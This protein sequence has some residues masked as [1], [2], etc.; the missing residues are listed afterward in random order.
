MKGEKKMGETAQHISKV[1]K[2]ELLNILNIAYSEEWLAYYQYWI[3]AQVAKGPM[4]KEIAEEFL[5]HANEELKHAQL[6]VNR[7]IQLGGTPVIDPN[8]WEKQALCKYASPTDEYVE[9][10]LKQNLVAER[11]AI[12]RYQQICD[13][14]HGKDYETFRISEKILKDEIEHEQEIEGFAEDIEITRSNMQ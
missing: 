3:G 4:R 2:E 8:E 14:T 12:S 5:E 10:L 6:L 11:C 7:I 9:T 1:N 13:M